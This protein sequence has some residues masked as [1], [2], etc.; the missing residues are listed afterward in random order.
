MKR[1]TK[2]VAL[3]TSLLVGVSMIGVG[4]ASWVIS[5][6]VEG[7]AT[8]NVTA[9]SVAVADVELEVT[10][11]DGATIHFGAPKDMNLPQAWLTNTESDKESLAV[12]FTIKL[13]GVDH[14]DLALHIDS[15]DKPTSDGTN[16]TEAQTR[17][18]VGDVTYSLGSVDSGSLAGRTDGTSNYEIGSSDGKITASKSQA[19]NM[20]TE[21]TIVVV[22][23]FKWGSHF[24]EQNPY[25]YYNTGKIA[26]ETRSD[27]PYGYSED[28]T[29]DTVFSNSHFEESPAGPITYQEDAYASLNMLNYLLQNQ[30]YN[31]VFT[32]YSK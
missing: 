31:F 30:H 15:Q 10:P 8:G 3:A 5:N 9:E 19:P 13:K 25:T 1:R 7:S 18:F 22:A 17:N 28:I 29:G 16:W 12:S 11:S 4:F 14:I 21:Y 23:T 20:S 2:V 27:N 6:S 24:G 32:A 26:G